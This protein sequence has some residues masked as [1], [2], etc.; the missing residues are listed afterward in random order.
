MKIFEYAALGLPIVATA[1]DE[2]RRRGLPF[3][4]VAQSPQDFSFQVAQI[5][6]NGLPSH[7]DAAIA[8]A[9]RQSWQEKCLS[10]LAHSIKAVA[11]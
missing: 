10:A 4:L 7:R 11:P 3:L 8:F 5:L 6:S 1:T 2:L 9:A